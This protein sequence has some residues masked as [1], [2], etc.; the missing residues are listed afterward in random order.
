MSFNYWLLTTSNKTI[1]LK[2]QRFTIFLVFFTYSYS[3][4]YWIPKNLKEMDAE[5]IALQ[6]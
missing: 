3:S 5:P 2:N 1:R 6:F 4:Q